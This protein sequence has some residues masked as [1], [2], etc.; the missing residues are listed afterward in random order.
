MNTVAFGTKRVFHGFL[1]V[2]R[3][4]LS[5]FGL[6][7]ARFDMLYAISPWSGGPPHAPS[8]R[9]SELRSMLGVSAPVVSRMLRSLEALGFV[10]RKRETCG[11]RRQVR[12][13]LTKRGLGCICR[14]RRIV[15]RGVRRIVLDAIVFSG[16]RDR[17]SQIDYKERLRSYLGA[18]RRAFGDTAWLSFP[19]PPAHPDD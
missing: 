13:T 4:L 6:T 16:R 9:Q 14:A 18:L 3:K 15:L 8:V 11:D 12:V 1:R 10:T 17:W 5:S 19:D 2:T 7:A